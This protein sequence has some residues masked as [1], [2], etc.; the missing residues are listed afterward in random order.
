MRCANCDIEISPEFSH[1]FRRN[2]CPACGEEILDEESLAMM[3]DIKE[4]ILSEVRLR[5]EAVARIALALVTNYSVSPLGS[6]APMA[7]RVAKHAPAAKRPPNEGV[8]R[9]KDLVDE[10]GSLLSE[11]EQMRIFEERVKARYNVELAGDNVVSAKKKDLSP[12]LK[13]LSSALSKELVSDSEMLNSPVLEAHRAERL[14]K[15]QRNQV[16]GPPSA[17]AGAMV[18]RAEP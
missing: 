15:Q 7:K 6:A 12:E 11:E 10:G 13:Q 4:T 3:D 16:S 5:D 8:I 14:A 18:S 1:A 17:R 9:Q 2:E